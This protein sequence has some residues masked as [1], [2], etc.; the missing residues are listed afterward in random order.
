MRST[1]EIGNDL[2]DGMHYLSVAVAGRALPAAELCEILT[3]LEG[4]GGYNLAEILGRLAL[5]I[6]RSLWGSEETDD[7]AIRQRLIAA[8]ARKAADH[9]SQIAL[10]LAA[11]HT[12]I[13]GRLIELSNPTSER[14][15]AQAPSSSWRAG[16]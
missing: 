15:Q 3:N 2:F 10:C 11:A 12:E 5:G 13:E 4:A 8:L 14:A 9:A 1:S 16:R 6:E 7:S